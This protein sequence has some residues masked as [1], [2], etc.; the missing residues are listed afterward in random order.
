VG[1]T[2]LGAQ[3]LVNSAE[4]G[5]KGAIY[6]FEES[7]ESIVKRCR[8]VGIR[9]D[10]AINGGKIIA[11]KINPMQLYPDELL[12]IIKKAVKE[13]K[14]KMVM[15]DSLKGYQI[16]MEQFGTLVTHLQN[17]VTYLNNMNLTT[18][19]VNE[20]EHITGDLRMTE[21]GVSFLVDNII[22][23]RYAEIDSE[24]KRIVGCLKKRLGS[25]KP[26]LR[27]FDITDRGIIVGSKLQGL[28]G[29]LTGVPEK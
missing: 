24:V 9:L 11:H 23:I 22:L 10:K 20:V 28:K 14:V 13:E 26:E 6:T 25:F 15:I 4:K 2:T 8:K 29:V 12:Y 17:I 19:I 7:V 5:S 16:A 18:I 21:V 27:E 1:K 3:F